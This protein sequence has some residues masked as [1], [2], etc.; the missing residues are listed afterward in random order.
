MR[1]R[2]C[3]QIHHDV[4]VGYPL[5]IAP[6]QILHTKQN[7]VTADTISY[8]SQGKTTLLSQKYPANIKFELVKCRSHLVQILVG[9]K[10]SDLNAQCHRRACVK[11][12]LASLTLVILEKF[13]KSSKLT[14]KP[15]QSFLP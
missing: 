15:H 3:S 13:S 14:I 4:H 9:F 11:F 6:Q 7:N 10:F 5:L 8:I 1:N 12:K 2:C